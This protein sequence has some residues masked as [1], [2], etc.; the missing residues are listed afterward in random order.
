[1]CEACPIIDWAEELPTV[2][3][4]PHERWHADM[5]D[6]HRLVRPV[7]PR[8]EAP[9]RRQERQPRRDD[10]GRAAGAAR[11]RDHHRRLPAALA[12]KELVELVNDLLHGIDHDDFAHNREV[13]EQDPR[14]DRD[15]ADARRGGRRTRHRV[16]RAVR[17]L[18]HR[19]S[20]GRGAVVGDGRG[21]AGCRFAGQQDTYLWVPAPSVLDHVQRCW[22]SLFTDRAI[23]YRHQMGYLHAA[24]RDVGRRAEDGR[25]D[26]IRRGVH[27]QPDQRRPLTGGDR[28]LLGSR[29]GGGV[30]RGHARQLPGRQGDPRDRAARDLRQTRRVSPHR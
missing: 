20:A 22:S 26:R 5:S 16:R 1:M 6:L 17:A 29:R 21:P 14:P 28:R 18:R 4:S 9:R 12:D 2:R 15:R 19:R 8:T 24:H 27:A 7:R 3:P 25:P 23:A 11:V 10:D 13:V 30:G